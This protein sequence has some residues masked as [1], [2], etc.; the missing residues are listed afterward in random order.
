ML[1]FNP[2][3]RAIP[4]NLTTLRDARAHMAEFYKAFQQEVPREIDERIDAV[5]GKAQ[6]CLVVATI[7]GVLWAKGARADAL[8]KVTMKAKAS[9]WT[10]SGTEDSVWFGLRIMCGSVWAAWLCLVLFD[11]VWFCLGSLVLFGQFS[12]SRLS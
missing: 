8:E 12:L 10:Q 2:N 5:I 4:A 3:V 11:S 9:V 7:A 6:L 1:V